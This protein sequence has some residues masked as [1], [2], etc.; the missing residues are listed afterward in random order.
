MAIVVQPV[1]RGYV[2]SLNLAA[3]SVGM[4]VGA[5]LAVLPEVLT[6]AFFL[7]AVL[8]TIYVGGYWWAFR[9]HDPSRRRAQDAGE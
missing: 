4:A 8:Q 7:A 5:A 3:G 6:P 1:E 2:Y 9:R